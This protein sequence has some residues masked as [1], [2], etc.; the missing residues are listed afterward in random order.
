[1][2]YGHYQEREGP[3]PYWIPTPTNVHA[4]LEALK[5]AHAE[6]AAM[7]HAR[8]DRLEAASRTARFGYNGG[9]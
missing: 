3:P 7:V 8:L 2:D 5:K 9:L 4:E 1:M 6:L